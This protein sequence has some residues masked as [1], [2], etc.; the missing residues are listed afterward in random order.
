MARLT[1]NDKKLGPITYARSSWNPLRLVFSTGGDGDDDSPCNTLTAYAFGWVARL[2][3]P[4]LA[5]P[6]RV[7]HKA[8]YWD[9]ATIERMGRDWYY[10]TFAR[11]F[12]F[13]LHDG[14]VSLYYGPQT[15]D[16][17]TTK[18]HGYFLPWTQWRFHR[19]TYYDAAGLEHWT[20]LRSEAKPFRTHGYD[21]Q[22]RAEETC[23]SVS[24]DIEDFDGARI[25]AKTVIEQREWKFGE[26]WFK[27][28]SLFRK[29]MIRRSL[30]IDFSAETG[31][32][33]GSWKGGTCGTSIDLMPNE[34]HESAFGR[35]CEQEHRSKYR[36][37]KVKFIGVIATP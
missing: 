7:K 20:Q 37:F 18:Q 31:P 14:H 33:K 25:V 35:Y 12:G 15:H 19:H 9:A 3:L 27:W 32:E 24:F 11:D 23:P 26:G 1:D 28:L 16:S 17:V 6:H 29:N 10:E 4:T 5:Q 8:T 13:C 22:Q 36:Q 34:L 2:R 21:E 30:K